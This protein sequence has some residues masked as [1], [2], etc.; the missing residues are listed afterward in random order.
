MLCYGLCNYH[1]EEMHAKNYAKRIA[2]KYPNSN[3]YITGHSL[4]G[5]LTQIG[6]AE[7]LEN[8]DIIPKKVVYFNGIGMNF[9]DHSGVSNLLKTITIEKL[10]EFTR[11]FHL[12]DMETL[13]QYASYNPLISYEIAGDVVSSLGSHCGQE[14]VFEAAEKSRNHHKGKYGD[15]DFTTW[16]GTV[17]SDFISDITGKKI[18]SYYSHYNV[19]S[20]IEYF[21]I[22]HETDSFLYHLNQG[23]RAWNSNPNNFNS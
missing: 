12:E 23:T 4:G 15:T 8:T 1:T 10:S 6:A 2:Q 21:W 17:L 13:T 16:V 22:T 14:I 11:F 18:S 9:I 19:H 20:I 7:L 5:Y 3:I